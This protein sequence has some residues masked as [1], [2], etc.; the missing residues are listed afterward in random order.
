M[1]GSAAAAFL[2]L[3]VPL[4]AAAAFAA[5]SG[6]DFLLD[7]EGEVELRQQAVEARISSIFVAGRLSGSGA[8][9]DHAAIVAFDP[10]TRAERWRY[11]RE[12]LDRSSR[13]G[14]VDADAGRVC[15]AGTI[16]TGEESASH[17]LVACFR[18]HTGV[19]LWER[20]LAGPGTAVGGVQADLS[21]RTLV[22]RTIVSSSGDPIPIPLPPGLDPYPYPPAGSRPLV[23]PGPYST[24]VLAF[25]ALTGSGARP[26]PFPWHGPPGGRGF[27]D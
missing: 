11:R 22:V 19:L 12:D 8:G 21:G 23:P 9:P 6:D 18:E 1:R 13:F 2:S 26:S 16:D 17:L 27:G 4:A 15:A 20:E 14:A 10:R 25:D 7:P 24:Q 3:L 5:E